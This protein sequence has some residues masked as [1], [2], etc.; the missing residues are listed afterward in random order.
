MVVEQ[1][2]AAAATTAYVDKLT[3]ASIDSMLAAGVLRI[4]VLDAMN[5]RQRKHA[6][7]LKIKGVEVEE[8]DFLAAHLKNMDG[9]SVY[10]ASWRVAGEIALAASRLIIEMQ[11]LLKRLNTKYQRETLRLFLAKNIVLTTQ[12]FVIRVQVAQAL[13]HPAQAKVWL[14]EPAYFSSELLVKYLPNTQ[15][16][17]YLAGPS[18]LLLLLKKLTGDYAR[19]IKRL[20]GWG[21]PIQKQKKS[22][23]SVLMMQED[24]IRLDRS[25]RGQLHWLDVSGNPPEFA[26]YIANLSPLYSVIDGAAELSKSGLALIHPPTVRAAWKKRKMSSSLRQLAQDGRAIRWAALLQRDFAGTAALLYA[27]QLFNEAERMG[28]L[29]TW[30]NVRVFL[31]HQLSADPIQLVAE[32]LNVRTIAFQYSNMG[33]RSPI[34]MTTSDYY[35]IFSEMYKTLFEH[36]GIAPKKWVIGGY[37]YDSIADIVRDRARTH[38]D[39]L[40]N[41]GAEFVVCYFDESV[42]HDRWGLISKDEHLAELHVLANAVLEDSSFGVVVKSQFMRNSPSQMYPTDELIRDAKATGR[43]LELK[44]GKLRND[45]YPTEAALVAD[46]CISQKFGA[47]AALE[48]AL[49]GVRTVL[50]N[51][52]G[53]KT[54]WDQLYSSAEIEFESIESLMAAISEFRAGTKEINSLGDWSSILNEFDPFRDGKASMRLYNHVKASLL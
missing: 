15:L 33:S 7:T 46:L 13:S 37:I 52:F 22:N 40:R 27:S 45:V 42:Q 24:T 35:V 50:I 14:A 41:N 39:A 1:S 26:A 43:F 28:A 44:E 29:V 51:K 8:A 21:Q 18:R 23:P 48:A 4:I 36:D 38:R 53:A 2:V 12:L 30:L 11:P 32:D 10:L 47:T 54:P 3:A 34:M 16:H 5:N 17:F 25:L 49:A 20:W 19:H 9:E 6:A 31:T